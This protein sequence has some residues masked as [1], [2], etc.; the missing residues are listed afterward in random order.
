VSYDF[1]EELSSRQLSNL[2]VE[3]SVLD[4]EG[5]ISS[6]WVRFAGFTTLQQCQP[7][8]RGLSHPFVT[9]QYILSEIATMGLYQ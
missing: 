2:L 8:I 7:C 6:W 5:I 1:P 9:V 3:G 4:V